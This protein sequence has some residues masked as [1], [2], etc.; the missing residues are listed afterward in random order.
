MKWIKAAGALLITMALAIVFSSQLGPVPALGPLLNPVSGFWQSDSS[1]H[2]AHHTWLTGM[3]LQDSVLVVYDDRRVPHI[4]ARNNHDVYFAQGYVH[5]QD[6]LWQ[7]DIQARSGAGTLAEILGESVVEIDKNQRRRGMMFGALNKLEMY[8]QDELMMPTLLAYT[9]GINAWIDRLSHRDYPLEYKLIGHAPQPWTPVHTLVMHMNMASTLA[10]GTSAAGM[11]N[12]R[13]ALG[14]AFI[15]QFLPAYPAD[16]DPIIPENTQWPF[17]PVQPAQAPGAF[18]PA[19][20]SEAHYDFPSPYLGS[21]SWA[22]SGYRTETG[23]PLLANDMHLEMSLPSIWYEVQLHTPEMNVYGVSLPGAPTVIVGFNSD[24]AWG[25]TN[26][27]ANVLDVFEITFED[28]S[29]ARY[30]HDGEWKETSYVVEEIP[31]A[32]AAAVI[33]TVWYTHHGPV[34]YLD[35]ENLKGQANQWIAHRGSVDLRTFYEI[36]RASS[37]DEFVSALGYFDV[38]A[39]NFTYADREGNVSIWHNGLFPVRWEGMGDFISDGSDPAYDWSEFIPRDHVP[40]ITNPERGFVSSAN[41]NPTDQEYPYFLGRFFAS[42]ERGARI[43]EVLSER[44]D[45]TY[46]DMLALQLDNVSLTARTGLPVMLELLEASEAYSEL[47]SEEH[48]LIDIMRSWDFEMLGDAIE[49]AIFRMW[50]AETRRKIWN[51]VFGRVERSPVRIP[52]NSRTI[53]LMSDEAEY[54][55]MLAEFTGGNGQPLPDLVADAWTAALEDLEDRL[56]QRE[57]WTWADF[58]NVRVI[59]LGRIDAL[60]R[61]GIQTHGA[62]EAVN[63]IRG[64]V[65]PSWRMVVSLEDDIRA[66]GV[67]PGGQSGSPGSV[68]Y[69]DFIEPWAEGSFFP[70]HFFESGEDAI[71]WIQQGNKTERISP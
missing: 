70:L 34:R 17:N 39:Q 68:H 9:D 30:L 2:K 24:I 59:H 66:W 54:E 29:L 31:V 37:Y 48:E 3:G 42:Y 45:F 40:N 26:S 19:T 38:P 20:L 1:Q 4:F 71:N 6:R 16:M 49:P 50:M 63:S 67:Y 58:Q 57:N 7:M 23:R 60:S 52:D 69:D 43:N 33:D 15:E 22:V 56:G 14:D 62:S 51:Q 28:A 46:R 44:Y 25:F 27:G 10:S 61:A 8:E 5:A 32:G 55:A 18:S 47:S 64:S 36:N 11:S 35:R 41:Q 12:V 53:Q 65:G 21:N 13:E